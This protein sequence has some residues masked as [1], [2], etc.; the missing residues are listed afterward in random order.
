MPVRSALL[1]FRLGGERFALRAEAV[2]EVIP[3]VLPGALP[4]PAGVVAGSVVVRGQLMALLDVR[5]SLAL[6]ARVIGAS[7]HYLIVTTGARTYALVTEGVDDFASFEA[8]QLVPARM[9]SERGPAGA[10]VAQLAD[11]TWAVLDLEAFL[12]AAQQ[13]ELDAALSAAGSDAT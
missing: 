6:P 4:F 10:N 2:I 1:R 9:L 8:A 7:D 12:S 13:A 5:E 11:G 3:A